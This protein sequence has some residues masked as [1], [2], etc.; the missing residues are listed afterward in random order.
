[1]GAMVSV[2][3]CCLQV[4]TLFRVL[5]R[6]I[7]WSPVDLHVN[8]L[9][10]TSTPQHAYGWGCPRTSHRVNVR[11]KGPACVWVG[12]CVVALG[13]KYWQ[14]CCWIGIVGQ[15]WLKS[16][17]L[18]PSTGTLNPLMRSYTHLVAAGRC[19]PWVPRV[20]AAGEV[21]RGPK[22]P[23]PLLAC[24]GVGLKPPSPLRGRYGRLWCSFRMQR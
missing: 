8:P 18:G 12:R 6:Y 5:T 24:V 15:W 17:H 14:R 20:G 7:A 11:V 21:A 4:S 22:P 19:R 23:S 9:I 2:V 3:A 10:R 1:M 16:W 13:R